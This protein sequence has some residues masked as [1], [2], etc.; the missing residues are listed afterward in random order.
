MKARR[1]F[2]F[3][4]V[5]YDS[6]IEEETPNDRAKFPAFVSYMSSNKQWIWI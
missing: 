6:Y 5:W 1:A 3:V 4:N 2:F